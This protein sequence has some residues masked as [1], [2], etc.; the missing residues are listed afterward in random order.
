MIKLSKLLS[1]FI[2]LL[3]FSVPV[4]A[5]STVKLKKKDY[6]RDIKLQTNQGDII[7]R[8]S[9]STPLHRDNFLKLVKSHFYDS[10]LFHRVINNFMI[11]GGDPASRTAVAGQALGNGGPGYTVPAEIRKT[12]FHQRGVLAA[13]RMGDDVNPQRASSG[14]QFYIVKGRTYT[15]A[16][17]DSLQQFRLRGRIFT[18]AERAAYTTVGGTPHLDQSYTVFGEVV[19][20]MDVV[21]LIS[22]TATSKGVDRDRPLENM[23]II[24]ATLIK[25]KKYKK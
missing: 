19:K 4:V 1:L 23:T 8:L 13:A 5:Q 25:R 18:D 11:Q 17:L 9:D 15:N 24:K 20:G 10:T 3:S 12:L 7:I 16:G 2:L 21:E 14:S 22:S 6:K